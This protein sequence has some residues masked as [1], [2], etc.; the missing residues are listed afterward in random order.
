M[1]VNKHRLQLLSLH[2]LGVDPNMIWS[3]SCKNKNLFLLLINTIGYILKLNKKCYHSFN[4]TQYLQ[5]FCMKILINVKHFSNSDTMYDIINKSSC[6]Q[7]IATIQHVADKAQ[8]LDI[9]PHFFP[10]KIYILHLAWRF[11]PATPQV[12]GEHHCATQTSTMC[13]LSTRISKY[14]KLM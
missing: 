11:E 14:I 1:S 4:I 13:H 10:N 8:Y 6:L 7:T 5:Y 9:R 3:T 12:W 2:P